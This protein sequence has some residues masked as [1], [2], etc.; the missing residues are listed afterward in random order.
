MVPVVA[1]AKLLGELILVGVICGIIVHY[2]V[3]KVRGLELEETER[4]E[5]ERHHLPFRFCHWAFGGGMIG[6]AVTGGALFLY[7]NL[8]RGAFE[9]LLGVRVTT[10][11]V[12]QLHLY[13]AFWT[14]AAFL[15]FGAYVVVTGEVKVYLKFAEAIEYFIYDDLLP[16]FGLRPHPTEDPILYD[17]ERGEYVRKAVPT[18]PMVFFGFGGLTLILFITGAALAFPDLL[19]PVWDVAWVVAPYLGVEAQDVLRAIHR[20]FAYLLVSLV[21][22][23]FYATLVF[24]VTGSIITGKRAEKVVRRGGEA[25]EASPTSGEAPS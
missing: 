22:M 9:W 2:I 16:W 13:L 24:G 25:R 15:A 7:P 6:L 21:F 1:I 12:L 11:Q 20:L 17:P 4:V 19:K 14:F 23:H 5:V 3:K 10:E 8:I 18:A